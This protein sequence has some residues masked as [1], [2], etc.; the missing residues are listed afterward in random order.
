MPD[1]FCNVHVR[2]EQKVHE[3]LPAKGDEE[4]IDASNDRICEPTPNVLVNVTESITIGGMEIW[5][6]KESCDVINNGDYLTLEHGPGRRLLELKQGGDEREVVHVLWKRCR[7]KRR[8]RCRGKIHTDMT[9][10]HRIGDDGTLYSDTDERECE[11][12]LND[13]MMTYFPSGFTI[14]KATS[15]ETTFYG[16]TMN[17]ILQRCANPDGYATGADKKT[18]TGR[19]NR[20]AEIAHDIDSGIHHWNSSKFPYGNSSWLNVN[21]PNPQVP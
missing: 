16:E 12:H 21:A 15:L 1:F 6:A 19:A 11:I 14:R 4:V 20:P 17:G 3:C 7:C 9:C 5:A 2:E 18:M 8:H 13:P 10:A